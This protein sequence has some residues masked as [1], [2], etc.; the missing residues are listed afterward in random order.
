MIVGLI[1]V[2]RRYGW[3]LKIL[4]IGSSAGLN[5]LIDRY[6]FDLGGALLGP[7]DSPV[8]I[9]PE[10]HGK[11]FVV[12]DIEIVSTRSCD[13]VPLDAT[14]PAVATRLAAYVWAEMLS[15][16]DRL[17]RAIKMVMQMPVRLDRADAADWLEKRL[18]EPQQEETTRVV[19][20]SVVWHYLPDDTARRVRAASRT[21]AKQATNRHPLGW[22]SMEPDRV[23]AEHVVSLACWPGD[24]RRGVI[25]IAHAHAE[26]IRFGV[27]GASLPQL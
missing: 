24:G 25:A 20:H 3:R 21:A 7:S 12:P 19:M 13:V 22:V 10:W 5:L 27:D 1:E 4:E 17:E 8:T 14:V 23:A 26:W 15:R 2:A 6:R 18:A 11:S 16:R 9:T